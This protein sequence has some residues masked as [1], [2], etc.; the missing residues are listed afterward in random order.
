MLKTPTVLAFERKL[1]NSDALMF[2]GMWE[3]RGKHD[4]WKEIIVT[5][6]KNRGVIGNKLPADIIENEEAMQKEVE[7]PNLVWGDETT[8][9]LNH[10]HNTL[11]MYFTLRVIEGLKTPSV[12]NRPEYQ[13]KILSIVDTY[14]TNYKFDELSKRYAINIANGR[15]LW[16]NRVG[17]EEIEIRV[18]SKNLEKEI[19]FDAYDYPIHDFN[20]PV[21]KVDNI[22]KIK[23]VANVIKQGLSGNSSTFMEIEAYVKLGPGQRVWPSQEMVMGVKEGEKSRYLFS[24][25]GCAAMHSQKIGNALRTIDTWYAKK[26]ELEPIAIEPYGSVTHRGKAYRTSKNDFY[27]LRDRWFIDDDPNLTDDDKHFVIAVLI[28]GGVFG[29]KDNETESKKGKKSGKE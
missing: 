13:D 10:G 2:S 23:Q 17:A 24:L 11:K 20:L 6:R 8:L 14:A 26:D 7:R 22:H 27:T 25:S 28:R 15:F 16:R 21:D 5:D 1:E 18:K 12:C 19:I 3:N 29:E 9:P 4:G